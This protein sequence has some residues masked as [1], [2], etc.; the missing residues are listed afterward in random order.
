[1]ASQMFLLHSTEE[2]I[3]VN[4]NWKQILLEN[5]GDNDAKLMHRAFEYFK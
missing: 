3:V 4:P 5:S 2:D 1:M